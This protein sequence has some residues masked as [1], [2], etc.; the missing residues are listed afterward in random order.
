MYQ[1]SSR[2]IPLVCNSESVKD[3]KEV[4]D[5]SVE[6]GVWEAAVERHKERERVWEKERPAC[7]EGE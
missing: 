6:G 5:I 2:S 3:G 7:G 4:V 1:F